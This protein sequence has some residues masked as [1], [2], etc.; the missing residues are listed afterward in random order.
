[1]KDVNERVADHT[2]R[3][4]EKGLVNIRVWGRPE[5]REAVKIVAMKGAFSGD[6]HTLTT[7]LAS[8]Q[9]KA[10]G[11]RSSLVNKVEENNALR[12]RLSKSKSG[13]GGLAEIE[14]L[15]KVIVDL[16]FELEG[17]SQFGNENQKKIPA[18]MVALNVPIHP[19]KRATIEAFINGQNLAQELINKRKA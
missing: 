7:R 11:Y 6:T 2:R 8:V 10:E 12:R 1:M 15:N 19:E 9:A 14:R 16:E 4:K 17:E 5:Y 3:Q 18:G 13:G